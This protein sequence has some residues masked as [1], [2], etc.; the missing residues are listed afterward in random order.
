[1]NRCLIHEKSNVIPISPSSP[2]RKTINEYSLKE[3]FF[4]PSKSSPPNEFM[5]KLQER[6]SIYNTLPFYSSFSPVSVS[7]LSVSPLSFI[8][9][10]NR[11]IE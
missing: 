4:D 9:E 6:M 1:M 11:D 3:N 7:P 10:D 2:T 8:K 5:K